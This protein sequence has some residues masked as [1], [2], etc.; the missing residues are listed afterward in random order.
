MKRILASL[1]IAATAY[2]A[3][4]SMYWQDNSDNESG[5]EVWR[6]VNE[7]VWELVGAT[8]ADDADFIDAGIPIGAIIKYRV[9]A[10]NQFGESGFT[11]EVMIGTFPP[12]APSGLNGQIQKSNPSAYIGPKYK[13]KIRTSRDHLGRIVISGS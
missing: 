1:L 4:V 9:R 2:S 10:F 12:A 11:N 5:F 13:G 3:D 8:S 6:Q 7:G